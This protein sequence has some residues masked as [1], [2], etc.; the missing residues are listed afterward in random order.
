VTR[1]QAAGILVVMGGIAFG[2][3]GGEYSTLDWWTLRRSL[4]DEQAAI[5]RLEQEE[6]SL[7]GL[8]RSLEADPAAQERAAREAFGMLRPGEV[9]FRVEPGIA[10]DTGRR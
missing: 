10:P 4:A 5:Q 6:D 9:L 7:A 2:A 1:Y 8:A 3:M